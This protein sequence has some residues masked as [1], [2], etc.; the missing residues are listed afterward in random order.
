[1]LCTG[2]AFFRGTGPYSAGNLALQADI[3]CAPCRYN[4]NCPDPVCREILSVDAVYDAC[5]ATLR[6]KRPDDRG[7]GVKIFQSFFGGDGYLDWQRCDD[8]DAGVEALGERYGRM[9]KSCL[10]DRASF[11]P[12]TE[13]SADGIS[14][15]RGS[16]LVRIAGHGMEISAAIAATARLT[17]LPLG[18][19]T[20]LGDAETGLAGRM[21]LYSAL[22]PECAPLID[23]FSLMRDNIVTEDLPTIAEETR[24]CYAWAR[25][26]A[27]SL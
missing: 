12:S 6:G 5:C 17:P 11:P 27:S 4:F 19:L 15:G 26:L 24:R 3:P 25:H 10:D 16:E 13:I 18:E 8:G 1:M 7:H 23:F 21:K 20:H 22:H 2:P 9:W 14:D